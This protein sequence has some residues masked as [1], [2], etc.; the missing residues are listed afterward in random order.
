MSSLTTEK[1]VLQKFRQRIKEKTIEV[2]KEFEKINGDK[3]K[4]KI[5]KKKYPNL[6]RRCK[7]SRNYINKKSKK[8]HFY[9]LLKEW[10]EILKDEFSEDKKTIYE[11]VVK[12][13]K[14]IYKHAQSCKTGLCNQRIL[15]MMKSEEK[16]IT[17]CVTKNTLEANEQWFR[18]LLSEIKKKYPNKSLADLVMVVSSKKVKGVTHCKNMNDVWSK[19]S[20]E[21]EFKVIFCCSNA[22]RINDILDLTTKYNNL[23]PTLRKNIRIIHDEAHNPK[24][25]IPP[26]RDVIENILLDTNVLSYCPCTAS[27]FVKE[28]GIADEKNP[29]WNIKN[30]KNNGI[31]YT[32]FDKTKSDSPNYSSCVDAKKFN[33]EELKKSSKWKSNTQTQV[34][35]ELYKKVHSDDIQK[36]L[37][38][39]VK[40]LETEIKK[41]YDPKCLKTGNYKW[42]DDLHEHVDI[43]N[44]IIA[45]KEVP[46]EMLETVLED[47]YV[48]RKRELEFCTFMKQDKEKQAMENGLN[49]LNMN[50]LTD[51]NFYKHDEFGLYIIN[52]PNRKIITRLLSEE[53]LK[54]KYLKPLK[55]KKKIRIRKRMDLNPIV[56]AIYG[57]EG[58][59][60]HL[61]FDGKEMCVDNIM[62]NGEFNEKLLKLKT[63]LENLLKINTKR[64]FIII[65]NYNPCGE[66]ISFAHTDYGTVR[67]VLACTSQEVDKDYQV[68]C[69]GNAVDNHFVKKFGSE[70]KFPEKFLVGTKE[71]IEN[72]MEGELQ[73][74]N[75]VDDYLACEGDQSDKEIQINLDYRQRE[76][77]FNNGTVATPIKLVII[78]DCSKFSELSAIMNIQKK[79]TEQKN[80]FMKILKEM[81]DNDELYEFTD[82]T[83]KFDWSNQSLIQFRRYQ[84]GYKAETYRFKNYQNHHEQN[85][86]YINNKSKIKPN[87][88]EILTCKDHYKLKYNNGTKTYNNLKNTWWIGYKY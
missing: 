53:A 41:F 10:F 73:N 61:L 21:N 83:G 76:E 27:A 72:V 38:N 80:D 29:V 74:D 88:C 18:R 60:Y 34:S 77:E 12:K 63:H 20:V 49:Y 33:C 47:L 86:E 84:E 5:F 43:Y 67:A 1:P 6:T 15:F 40:R 58:N 59:K 36:V 3:E 85:V 4:L 87:Q 51:S 2:Q 42:I 81:Y 50:I 28:K 75:Q 9:P 39:G 52:T 69:R 25:G 11:Y 44:K 78:D 31:N 45:G 48:N 62:V 71:F 14:G 17:I 16:T 54:M 82:K 56:L 7:K 35:K 70:W 37:S 46:K 8:I 30:L 22:T 66:S 26:N 13:I 57:N 64:P 23:V 68:G 55:K 24:E 79:T 32:E 65:G 19:L